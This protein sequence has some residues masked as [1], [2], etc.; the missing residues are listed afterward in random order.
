VLIAVAGCFPVD[1]LR[2]PADWPPTAKSLFVGSRG[3][4]P[5]LI[6]SPST[7]AIALSRRDGEPVDLAAD[8]RS[9][10]ELQIDPGA[11]PIAVVPEDACATGDRRT[12]RARWSST[13]DGWT[14][15]ESVDPPIAFPIPPLDHAE[16]R[17]RERSCVEHA[18]GV[19][20]ACLDA[21]AVAAPDLPRPPEAVEPPRFDPDLDACAPGEL[22]AIG[23]EGC[24]PL[25]TPCAG[26]WPDGPAGERVGLTDS[27]A[28]AVLRIPAGGTI[29]LA[30]G[31]H[32]IAARI[33]IARDVRIVGCSGETILAPNAGIEVS[34]G[35]LVIESLR[36]ESP[37]PIAVTGGRL[38]TYGVEVSTGGGGVEVVAP[39]SA[40]F[41]RVIVTAGGKGI[42]ASGAAVTIGRSHVVG[43]ARAIEAVASAAVTLVDARVSSATAIAV[44]VEGSTL[45]FDRLLV[46]PSNRGIDLEGGGLVTGRDL[47][48]RAPISAGIVVQASVDHSAR[49]EFERFLIEGP[50]CEGVEEGSCAAVV[51]GSTREE[52]DQ[53]ARFTDGTVVTLTPRGSA[54]IASRVTG[55]E[56]VRFAAGPAFDQTAIFVGQN[57][58]RPRLAI[59]DVAISTETHAVKGL[60]VEG[61]VD[62]S[63]IAVRGP[64]YYG[65]EMKGDGSAMEAEDLSV[66]GQVVGVIVLKNGPGRLAI[67]R[68]E[69]TNASM[70]GLI[71][72]DTARV[73]S[74]ED[75]TIDHAGVAFLLHPDTLDGHTITIARLAISGAGTGMDLI[76]VGTDENRVLLMSDVRVTGCGVAAMLSPCLSRVLASPRIVFEDNAVGLQ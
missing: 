26:D 31:R 11:V 27:L 51:V 49:G 15:S 43:E 10:E 21:C 52:R 70:N 42:L 37:S 67:S 41:D 59:S 73:Q 23:T 20:W 72:Q 65:V 12:L 7:A 45:T 71:L 16:C 17:A 56:I 38:E 30:K 64:F 69:I 76:R 57:P 33:D 32:A 22:H 4:E 40:S 53:S 25:G 28:D 19:P 39:A 48:V 8:D 62:L 13:N 34:N 24:A 55:M 54:L 2:L 14:S 1:D 46:D 9:L 44:F 63:R 60:G 5:E 35:T 29:A 6:A 3:L 75:I 74:L 36:I 58:A 47:I 50:T 66:E 61:Q 18:G 68:A